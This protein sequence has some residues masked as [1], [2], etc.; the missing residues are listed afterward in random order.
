MFWFIFVQCLF[1]SAVVFGATIHVARH[2]AQ[3][4][5]ATKDTK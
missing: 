4:G 5:P 3:F 1:D 2:K